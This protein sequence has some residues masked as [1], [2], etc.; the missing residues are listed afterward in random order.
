M[1]T[2]TVNG[3][4]IDELLARNRALFGTV[5]MELTD[6]EKAKAAAD[7]AAAAGDDDEL[8]D[9]EKAKAAAD[10]AA[11]AGDDDEL[12]DEEKAAKAALG[13]AGK[14]ALDRMK[15]KWQKER[16]RARDAEARLAEATKKKPADGEQP[17][18][19]E[20]RAE[21]EKAATAKVNQ[22]IVRSEV[23]A[24]AAG[25]L[26]DPRD[27]ITLLDLSKFDVDEDGNVDEDE[28]A[29]AIDELLKNKPYLGVTQ[30]DSKKFKGGA[31]AGPRGN[32]KAGKPQLTEADVKKLAAEGKHAEI[33]KA[34]KEGRLNELL[35]IKSTT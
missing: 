6:E 18:P 23:R 34:R 3:L 5:R 11:A 7:A 32:G 24:A 4:T 17:D 13:D 27:A 12:T 10:A 19:D 1:H 2:L 30:G 26:Q 21:A 31:D 33:E 16:D 9:E 25:K 15:A 20:I 35:G 8:T 14:Q 22:R 29:D 28:I